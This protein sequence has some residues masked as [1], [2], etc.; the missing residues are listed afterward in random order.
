MRGHGMAVVG[1]DVHWTVFRSVYTELN[2]RIEL[3]ALKLGQPKFM[4]QYE[5]NRTD[6]IDRSWNQWVHDMES[7]K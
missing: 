7:R 2:A 1:P 4:N 3:E 6:R 5:V